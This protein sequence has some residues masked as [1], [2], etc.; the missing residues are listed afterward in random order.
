[1]I[2]LEY[3][4]ETFIGVVTT[5]FLEEPVI[6]EFDEISGNLPKFPRNVLTFRKMSRNFWK[7]QGNF[8]DI[9]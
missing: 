5:E 6:W 9:S 1:M 4:N 7:F 3:E 2:T 8:K